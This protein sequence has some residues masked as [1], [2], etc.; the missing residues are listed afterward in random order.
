MRSRLPAD[1]A[2]QNSQLGGKR[3]ARGI[4]PGVWKQKKSIQEGFQM[5]DLIFELVQEFG[6]SE[7]E[8]AQL[9]DAFGDL[10]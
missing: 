1:A 10:D 6:L 7:S 2:A 5:M 3:P 9:V 8:A 4:P